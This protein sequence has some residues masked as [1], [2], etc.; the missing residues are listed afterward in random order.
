MRESGGQWRAVDVTFEGISVIKNLHE[1]FKEVL[2]AG[3]PERLLQM[4][5]EKNGSRS[6]C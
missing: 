6:D 3:G 5:R 4:L 2:S 1:Q